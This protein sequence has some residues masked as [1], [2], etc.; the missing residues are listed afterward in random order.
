[1]SYLSNT[2]M[3]LFLLVMIQGCSETEKQHKSHQVGVTVPLYIY[4]T[5][6]NIYTGNTYW[7]E[8][9]DSAGENIELTA[10]INPT[11]GNHGRYPDKEFREGIKA[12]QNNCISTLG[13][14]YTK[15]GHRKSSVVIKS[16]DTYRDF[17]DVDGIFFDESNSSAA[18]INY[19][20]NLQI[21][22]RVESE[23][24][25]SIINPGVV[26]DRPFIDRSNSLSKV[27]VFEGSYATF[28]HSRIDLSAFKGKKN[29]FICL[30]YETPS[31]K[32]KRAVN[33]AIE[34]QCG[35]IYV[36]DD[37]GDNP[38]DTLPKYWHDFIAYVAQI[39]NR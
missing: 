16:I 26:P 11:N 29:S 14:V 27:V 1:M 32:M 20:Q 19:Y 18:A 24:Q 31:F 22:M 21:R 38:W 23:M 10:I 30:I 36:T 4:P 12:L 28:E 13:Y 7:E 17:Y 6:V 8:L 35:H 3:F 9:I 39:N 33:L 15:Y 25:Q 34:K 2:V 37:G 5:T